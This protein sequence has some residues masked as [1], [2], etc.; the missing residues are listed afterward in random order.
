MHEDLARRRRATS[1]AVALAAHLSMHATASPAW[2]PGTSALIVTVRNWSADRPPRRTGWPSNARPLARVASASGAGPCRRAR[3]PTDAVTI[4]A[5]A[6]DRRRAGMRR[7]PATGRGRRRRGR[8]SAVGARAGRCRCNHRRRAVPARVSRAARAA[9]P[10]L[11]RHDPAHQ[12]SADRA[13][14]IAPMTIDDARRRPAGRRVVGH[15]L[16]DISPPGRG[17]AIGNRSRNERR[18][19]YRSTGRRRLGPDGDRHSRHDRRGRRPEPPRRAATTTRRVVT[20]A[21]TGRARRTM[22]PLAASRSAPGCGVGEP[23]RRPSGRPVARRGR[24][25]EQRAA[26]ADDPRPA[27]HGA[28]QRPAAAPGRGDRRR[29]GRGSRLSRGR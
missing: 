8:R 7:R 4:A 5:L 10:R 13:P 3:G 20:T 22:T 1:R 17:F 27:S 28:D 21:P 6:V 24:C 16:M 29:R 18:R 25:P 12:T 23:M 26:C 15:G 14:A 2:T 11:G 9:R 19:S